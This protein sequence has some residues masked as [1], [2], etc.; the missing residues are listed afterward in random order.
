MELPQS[1]DLETCCDGVCHGQE[2]PAP[3]PDS[4]LAARGVSIRYGKKLALENVDLDIQQGRV[5]AL[6]GPSGCG[7]TS[8]LSSLN[9]MSDL[10]PGA[11]VEGQI[12][13][14]GDDVLGHAADVDQLR[15]RIGMVF[16]RP[17]LFPLSI[18]KNLHLPLKEHGCPRDQIDARTEEVLR[19]VGLWEE[20]AERLDSP[21]LELS[22][23]QQQRLCIARALTLRPRLLLMDEP[24]S[25]LDPISTDVIERL[26]TSMRGEYTIVIV[27]HNLAQAQR[28]ADDVAVFWCHAES[29]C[30]IESGP[31]SSVFSKPQ[32]PDTRAYLA[33]LRG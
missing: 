3:G 4:F 5:T 22:G 32:Q 6:I 31:A 2:L 20:V 23:G 19:E 21:A 25:A 18:A 27:T 7:K 10:I 29:G 17:N 24:C 9:R 30:V 14:E 8:F 13:F 28:I 16:Q 12:L 33:G 11:K 15:R 26:I 1:K